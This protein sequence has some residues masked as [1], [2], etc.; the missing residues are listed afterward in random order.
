MCEWATLGRE[1]L[2][3]VVVDLGK[4]YDS[5]DSGRLYTTLAGL[6]LGLAPGLVATHKLMYAIVR[7]QPLLGC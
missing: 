5:V 3:M 4:A 6:S 2:F 7:V 1:L